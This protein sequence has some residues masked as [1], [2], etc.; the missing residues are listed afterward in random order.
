MQFEEN[1]FNTSMDEMEYTRGGG[2][3]GATKLA[4]L[5]SNYIPWK[6]YFDIIHD[7]DLFLFYDEVQYTTRDWRSRNR[8]KTEH[9]LKWL[10]IPCGRDVKRMIYEVGLKPEEWQARHY[11]V[12]RQSYRNAPYYHKY[13]EFLRY[14]Y[15]EKKWDYLYELNRFMI[16]HISREFLGITTKFEDSR[17]YHSSGR[18]AEKLFELV[19][20]TKAD[21]YISGPAAKDY[22][23][24]EKYEEAGIEVIWKDYQGYPQYE[25]LHGEFCHNV[26]ILDLLFHTGDSAPYYIWG[27]RE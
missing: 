6:G 12:L 4:V 13:D 9:G 14:V 24:L 8:I 5:Q 17:N 10:T 25:Q 11:N 22:M 2:I 23:Q 18:K 1:M 26:S 7:V 27:W 16:E 19:K 20:D 15:L 21:I 3:M